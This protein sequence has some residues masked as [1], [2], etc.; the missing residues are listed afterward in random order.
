M[1]GRIFQ[2]REKIS[3]EI[4]TLRMRLRMLMSPRY[5]KEKEIDLNN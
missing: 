5:V 3:N 4:Y 1:Y 2:K